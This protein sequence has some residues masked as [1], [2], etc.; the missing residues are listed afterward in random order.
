MKTYTVQKQVSKYELWNAKIE[1]NSPE[2]AER[3]VLEGKGDWRYTC[4]LD[5]DEVLLNV[6]ELEVNTK[7][8]EKQ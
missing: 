2:E 4:N 8:R 5:E 1:A 3:L 6:D 7:E